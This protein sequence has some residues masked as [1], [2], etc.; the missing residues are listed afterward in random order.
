MPNLEELP[1]LQE[2]GPVDRQDFVQEIVKPGLPVVLRRQF[3][4][5]PICQAARQGHQSA[6]RYVA[7]WDRGHQV[8]TVFGDPS[9]KGRFFYSEDL[10]GLNFE[11]RPS[12]I[13]AALHAITSEVSAD[14]GSVYV[15]SVPVAEHL[16]G[17]E[18]DNPAGLA[19]EGVAPRIWIGGPLRV[20]THFDLKENL[21]VVAAGRREFILFPPEQL[22][23]L[24]PGPFEHTLAGPPV[25]MVDLDDPDHARYPRFA[26]AMSRAR[27]AV[28]EPGDAIYIPYF[29]WHHIRSLDGFNIL[30]NYWWNDSRADLGSPYDALLHTVL[31]IRDMPDRQRDIWR[32]V[33]GYYAFGSHGDPVAHLPPAARGALGVHDE[34]SRLHLWATLTQAAG[35]QTAKLRQIFGRG[36]KP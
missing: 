13:A 20:Q 31:A 10:T 9:I 24:Y 25:S 15:Q 3:G 14:R 32:H 5:W 26:E 17:L 12:T 33:F 19:P 22:A 34:R 2:R 36:N 29:W 11:K 16:P 23:N 6:A 30:L 21:A 1:P 8:E 27:R 18:R 7:G 4:N 35:M 28:L